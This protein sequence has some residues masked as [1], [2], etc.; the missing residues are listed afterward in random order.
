[1]KYLILYLLFLGIMHESEAKGKDST[2]R[3]PFIKKFYASG[4]AG[5]KNTLMASG[6]CLIRHDHFFTFQYLNRSATAAS[7]G[8]G[9]LSSNIEK[10]YECF[11]L[12][13]G[14]SFQWKFV[15]FNASAGPSYVKYTE[16]TD[17]K[18]H[19]GLWFGP[20]YTATNI[21]HRLVGAFVDGQIILLTRFFGIGIEGYANVNKY[22]NPMGL[23]VT[24]NL[25]LL[26]RGKVDV[27]HLIWKPGR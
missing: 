7:T 10:T 11:S 17:I 25:G 23:L 14:K 16:P 19:R 26:N 4:G 24:L 8:G 5:S 15:F 6:S 13:Y 1:M 27:H 18:Y 9:F 3:E 22:N 2:A 20:Y 21:N 12:A